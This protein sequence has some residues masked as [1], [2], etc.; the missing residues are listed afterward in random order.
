MRNRPPQSKNMMQNKDKLVSIITPL[1]NGEK[2]IQK[3]IE[4]VQ[5]QTYKEWEM[6]I[7]DDCS[8]DHGPDIVL[9]LASQ[10]SRIRYYR[11][12]T[13]KKAAMTRNR[14]IELSKGRYIA[15]LDSDDLWKPDKLEK[16]IG[17]LWKKNAAFCYSACEV[18]DENDVP[19]GKIRHVPEQLNYKQLLKGNVIPCLTVVLD[20][21]K[22]SHISM[23]DIGHE[24]YA[25]WLN[26]L[27][28]CGIAYGID[29]VLGSYRIVENSLSGNKVT[30]AKWTWRI[31]REYLGLSILESSYYFGNYILGAIKKRV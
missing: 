21:E 22:F 24:D 16:Q 3:T 4:S 17:L 13:N 7:V 23:P 18:I 27:R 28:G 30:A 15:F 11:N 2:Y 31:Y 26:L 8:S 6:I 19:N 20:K 29:E 9:E 5:N 14:A 10:D 25:T 12:E 1:Y